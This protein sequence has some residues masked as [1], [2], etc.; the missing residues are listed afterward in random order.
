[1]LFTIVH[2]R[3]STYIGQSLD[4][5]VAELHGDNVFGDRIWR[6]QFEM[7]RLSHERHAHG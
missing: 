6:V 3:L 7:Q 4:R 1:M 2:L 5:R